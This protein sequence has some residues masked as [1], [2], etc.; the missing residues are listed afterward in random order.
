[1]NEVE[2]TEIAM[3]R[4]LYMMIESD[5]NVQVCAGLSKFDVWISVEGSSVELMFGSQRTFNVCRLHDFDHN[6]I[7]QS[8]SYFI[9]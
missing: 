7:L 3:S 5:L 2:P 1:M 9:N 6:K 8:H 4:N